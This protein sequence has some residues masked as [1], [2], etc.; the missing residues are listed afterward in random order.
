MK[1]TKAEVLN[2]AASTYANTLALQDAIR[3][4]HGCTVSPE[5]ALM[6]MADWQALQRRKVS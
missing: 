3:K 6:I 4:A 1:L 5:T 2:F